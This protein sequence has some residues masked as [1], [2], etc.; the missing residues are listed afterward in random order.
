MMQIANDPEI[1]ETKDP[2]LGIPIDG[3]DTLRPFHPCR[4]FVGPGDPTGKDKTGD[5]CLT[6]LPDLALK[7]QDLP[8]D[9]GSCATY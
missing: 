3:D 4:K 1:S 2:C 7:G 5:N 9:H 6:G 8:V